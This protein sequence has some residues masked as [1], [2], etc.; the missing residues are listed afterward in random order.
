M[1]QFQSGA[2][3]IDD[4]R[5]LGENKSGAFLRGGSKKEAWLYPARLQIRF[6]QF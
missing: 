6:D 4:I 2:S 3:E 1:V 5:R